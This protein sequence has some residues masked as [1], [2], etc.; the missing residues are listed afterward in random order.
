MPA[1]TLGFLLNANS[2][3]AGSVGGFLTPSL[4]APF[5]ARRSRQAIPAAARVPMVVPLSAVPGPWPVRFWRQLLRCLRLDPGVCGRQWG[6]VTPMPREAN[7][8][9]TG[10]WTSLSV[11]RW[12]PLLHCL[13]GGSVPSHLTATGSAGPRILTLTSPCAHPY[14]YTHT[15]WCAAKIA[16]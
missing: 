4:E 1:T 12:Q 11:C 5:W 2:P 13:E 7:V 9:Q 16:V 10:L 6:I 14:S 3:N 15:D 8:A